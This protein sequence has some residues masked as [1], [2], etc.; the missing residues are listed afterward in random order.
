LTQRDQFT[1]KQLPLCDRKIIQEQH[2][3]RLANHPFS[4]KSKGGRI[5]HEPSIQIGDLVYLHNDK[6]K[7]RARNRYIIV[8][9]DKQWCTIRKF[10][11]N[12]LRNTGYKVRTKDCYNV[13]SENKDKKLNQLLSQSDDEEDDNSTITP[14]VEITSPPHHR[15]ED[16]FNQYSDIPNSPDHN[17]S[18]SEAHNQ[19]SLER[20]NSTENHEQNQDDHTTFNIPRHSHRVRK[21]PT[22]LNDY[23]LS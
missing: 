19:L 11:G 13:P 14:P 5:P 12:Q 9:L 15:F 17:N 3:N 1:H 16:V 8:S 7:G 4:E 2:H 18:D 6:N 21:M 23:K 22:F 20:S 10:V